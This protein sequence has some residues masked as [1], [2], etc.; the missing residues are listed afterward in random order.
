MDNLTH[1]LVG[2]A[3][4]KSGLE[5]LSPGATTLCVLAANAPDVDVVLLAFTDRWT[6]LQ[7]HR[8]I[9]HAIV[10]VITLSILL[11]LIFLGVDLL[12]SKL[13]RRPLRVKFGGLMLASFLATATHPFLDWTNN[14]GLRPFLPWNSRW[15][16]GDLVFI[17]DP[18][19]WLLLG[20]ACFLLTTRTRVQKSIWIVIGVVSTLLILF[21][22][23]GGNLPYPW[24][25]RGLWIAILI[26]LIVLY[27]TQFASL[28]SRIP[29]AALVLLVIYWTALGFVHSRALIR[30]REEAEKMK[31]TGETISRVVAMPTLANPLGWDCVFETDKASYRFNLKLF[32]DSPVSR[33]V[34][35]EKPTGKTE[36]ALEAI[37]SD[38]RTKIFL[39]FARFPVVK[40]ADPDCTTQT[41]VQLADLRYTEPGTSRGNFSLELPVDC[42][43]I[44]A[45]A[46][47][48]A[49]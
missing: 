23:R 38:R 35:Y 36:Q 17:V 41:L 29:R 37:S 47:W 11:P 39:G 42:T 1:S 46:S 49:R 2:L 5:K 33:S 45:Q 48:P 7:N 21:T 26:G 12:I 16:Y 40:L 18:F 43:L 19:I 31:S 34:R 13:K 14:Y 3:A 25:I 10:G 22:P 9:T 6:T 8:G 15:F 28:G 24:L 27:R 20:S 30:A 44:G 4:A 32:N